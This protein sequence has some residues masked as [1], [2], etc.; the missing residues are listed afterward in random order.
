MSID[1]GQLKK[2]KAVELWKHEEHDFT[3]WL[4]TE[5]NIG[6][7]AEALGLEFQVEGIEAVF[8]R[9]FGEGRLR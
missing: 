6:R 2:V 8:G 7:L 9:H 4:A 1:L 3:P 5:E